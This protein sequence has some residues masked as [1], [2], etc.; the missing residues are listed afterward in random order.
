MN[1]DKL[2]V[3]NHNISKY[4]SEPSEAL[5]LAMQHCKLTNLV[6]ENE[7]E[8]ICKD[9]VRGGIRAFSQMGQRSIC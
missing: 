2:N 8:G 4:G 1:L 7:N 5:R 9:L 6:S 3:A